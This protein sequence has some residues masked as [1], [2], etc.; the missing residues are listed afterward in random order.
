MKH[1]RIIFKKIRCTLESI[2]FMS[3]ESGY[4]KHLEASKRKLFSSPPRLRRLATG[5]GTIVA[6]I[7]YF[8]FRQTCATKITI[9]TPAVGISGYVN[10]Q[11]EWTK[12]IL[13]RPVAGKPESRI[14]G[15]WN[16]RRSG[17]A[18]EPR[19]WW[20]WPSTTLGD[21]IYIVSRCVEARGR[22]MEC[23]RIGFPLHWC[24]TT[25]NHQRMRSMSG[26]SK[27]FMRRVTMP[28]ANRTALSAAGANIVCIGRIASRRNRNASALTLVTIGCLQPRAFLQNGAPVRLV[29]PVEVWL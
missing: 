12:V 27:Q 10:Y 20:I 14:S 3:V 19:S 29:V 1:E 17:K 15:R 2:F 21:V 26:I 18:I 16:Q 9:L 25:P 28:G 11:M 4:S 24:A 22:S 13:H 5:L 7:K 6:F 23:S 8:E